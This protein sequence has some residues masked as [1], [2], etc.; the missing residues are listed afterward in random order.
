MSSFSGEHTILPSAMSSCHSDLDL[1]ITSVA[2]PSTDHRRGAMDNYRPSLT[3]DLVDDCIHCL[4]RHS[5]W[6]YAVASTTTIH[7]KHGH[8]MNEVQPQY[9]RSTTTKEVWSRSTRASKRCTT[10]LWRK[11]YQRW[12]VAWPSCEGSTATTGWKRVPIGMKHNH[13]Q[14]EAYRH[15]H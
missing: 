6:H 7:R 15:H 14:K 5:N 1:P 9:E 8:H 3:Y 13:H 12:T 2:S 11:H 4:P 10:T